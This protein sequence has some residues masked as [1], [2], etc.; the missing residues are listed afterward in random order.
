MSLQ[1]N[2]RRK[3][4]KDISIAAGTAAMI[5]PFSLI[6]SPSKPFA[7]KEKLGVALVG[8]G[9]YSRSMLGPAL[10][11]TDNCYLSAIVTGTPEKAESWSKE[12]NIKQKNIYNYDNY[13]EIVNNDDIDIVYVVLPNSM[14][15]EFTI[16]ALNAGKHVICEKPFALNAAEC[17]QMIDAAKKAK[18]KLAVGYRMHY[19]PYFVDV[20]RMAQNEEMGPVNYLEGALA[21]S[22]T[23]R[24]GS[25]KLKKSMGGGSLYNLGVYPIQGVRHAKG[26]M[27][28]YVSAQA[29]TKR[30]DLFTEIPE[31]FTWQFEWDDGTL[32]SCYTGPNARLDRL[33]IGCTD[34]WI[35]NEPS[36][37][38]SGQA[39]TTSNGGSLDYPQVFQQKL[40]IEAFG[41]HV[42][43]NEE[44]LVDGD[45]GLKDALIIDAIHESI[46]TGQ[47]ARI[48]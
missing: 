20:K 30:K 10:K 47:K 16:R 48:G 40:Q 29:M 37:G 15:A 39:V 44:L 6:S 35:N 43:D 33:Y 24:A 26:S 38:Y 17:R 11:E 9:N 5:S 18:R 7:G 42:T 27:P 32:A 13:D 34:G 31:M 36:Y 28:A 1:S 8:L 14:H 12:Y 23:P 3:F 25:W 45:E 4:I 2:N 46:R 22:Y 19:D 21:Y 41:R